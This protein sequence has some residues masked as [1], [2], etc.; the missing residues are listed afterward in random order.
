MKTITLPLEEYEKLSNK[1]KAIDESKVYV[2]P[3]VFGCWGCDLEIVGLHENAT[4]LLLKAKE[5]HE[6]LQKEY[7]DYKKVNPI[8][9][10]CQKKEKGMFK[11]LFKW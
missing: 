7:W 5:A 10:E 3:S 9:I 4:T 6:K 8:K 2:S 1:A 11:N